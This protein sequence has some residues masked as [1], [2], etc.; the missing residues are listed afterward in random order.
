MIARMKSAALAAFAA[1]SLPLFGAS[2]AYNG[3]TWTDAV[4]L[5]Q[6]TCRYNDAKTYAKSHNTPMV[7]VWANPG[8]SYCATFEGNIGTSSLIEEW[9]QDR[10]YVMVFVLGDSAN[11]EYGLSAKDA[12]DAYDF[13]L[14]LNSGEF[15]M[16]GIWWPSDKS[17]K[18]VKAGFT[19][20]GGKM[21]VTS[22]TFAQQFMYSVDYYVGDYASVKPQTFTITFDA[23]GGTISAAE[24]TRVILDGK[25]IGTLPVATRA[26][27]KLVG[28]ATEKSGG[29]VVKSTTKAIGD[30]TYYAQWKRAVT[31]TLKDSPAGEGKLIGGGQYYEGT[32]VA[33]KAAPKNGGVFSCWKDGNGNVVSDIQ[34]FK[35]PLGGEDVTLTAYFISK[36]EDLDSISFKVDNSTWTESD[37]PD[38][39]LEQGVAVDWPVSVGAKTV[40][41][42][43]FSG[44]PSGLKLVKD[45]GTGAYSIAGVPT[46]VS[47]A[48]KNGNVKPSAVTLKIK[49]SGGNAKTYKMAITVK[50]RPSWTE[51]V[52]NGYVD[53]APDMG[54]P[55]GLVFNLTVAANGK[56]SGKLLCD[57]L[58]YTLSAPSLILDGSTYKAMIDGKAKGSVVSYIATFS[59]K[60]V[61][62][63]TYGI[64]TADKQWYAY[65]TPWKTNDKLKALAK[66]IAKA[67]PLSVSGALDSYGDL[68]LKFG[69]NGVVTVKGAGASSSSVLVPFSEEPTE[70]RLYPYLAPKKAFPGYA[71][72]IVLKW[73]G[74]RF[75]L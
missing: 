56:V 69:A 38:R 19:G 57:G 39:T 23:N 10:G 3:M 13:C 21:T 8:C 27:Y 47:K 14:K 70:F 62:S 58:T 6:W 41:T 24:K 22:G 53:A 43:S 20:R 50:A 61:A 15:P 25:T 34:K 4:S 2:Y 31:L 54:E 46:A 1:S 9:A 48:D 11:A 73:D 71:S 68:T 75:S 26:G 16:V 42:P 55:V 51:G 67:K 44:L 45:K 72:R 12:D 36:Q 17:G 30:A 5:G 63:Y 66:K 52:F 35:Y 29:A 33:V 59:K 49:T 65:Q 64:I 60:D 74:E 7:V 18:E 32:T 37:T 28:W 40:A